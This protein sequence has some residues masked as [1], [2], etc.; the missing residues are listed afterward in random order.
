MET[1]EKTLESYLDH[2]YERALELFKETEEYGLLEGRSNESERELQRRYDKEDFDFIVHK[3]DAYIMQAEYE[4]RF[5]Y[6]QAFK[7]CVNI[8]KELGILN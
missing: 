1:N 6:N 5:L 7:D 4:G 8:L 3:M 2:A